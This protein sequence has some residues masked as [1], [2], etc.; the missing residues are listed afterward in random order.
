MTPLEAATAAIR[1]GPLQMLVE[2]GATIDEHNYPVL[3]CAA[4]ARHNQDMIRLL[5]SRRSRQSPIDCTAVRTL[6]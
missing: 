5:E 3:W 4:M 1:T 6:W 2:S